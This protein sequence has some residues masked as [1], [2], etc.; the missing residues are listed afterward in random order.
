MA[1][2]LHGFLVIAIVFTPQIFRGRYRPLP[3]LGPIMVSIEGSGGPRAGGA[4]AARPVAAPLPEKPAP[5]AKAA[6][7]P[8][9]ARPA[10]DLAIPK[11]GKARP[12]AKTKTDDLRPDF[13]PVARQAS[14]TPPAPARVGPQTAI[15]APGPVASVAGPAGNGPSVDINLKTPGGSG[16]TGT[17]T[18]TLL[19]YF[20]RIQDK[21]SAFWMPG[22]LGD[23]EVI[24]L[25][26]I[27]LLHS[28]QVREITIE[29]S[30]GDRGFDDA[31]IRALRQAL[32]LPPFPAL[33]KEDSMNLILKFTNRG[34]GG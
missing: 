33:V 28:G 23:R 19:Y 4:A 17:G 22:A 25:V 14:P 1:V 30:S 7:T 12:A 15:T 9:P 10:D 2:A 6:P 8:A 16:G 29:R 31:A 32:P 5:P 21:V 26:G 27:R 20:A 11:P 13:G 18:D 3:D 24:V 34:I